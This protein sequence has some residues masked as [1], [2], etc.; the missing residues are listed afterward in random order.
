MPAFGVCNIN[1]LVRVSIVR[2]VAFPYKRLRVGMVF[3][4]VRSMLASR[5]YNWYAA[6]LIAWSNIANK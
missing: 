5:I 2:D 6:A 4:V 3:N 1:I